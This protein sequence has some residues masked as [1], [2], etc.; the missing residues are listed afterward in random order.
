MSIK[1]VKKAASLKI[2]QQLPDLETKI[3]MMLMADRADENGVFHAFNDE[4]IAQLTEEMNAV[5]WRLRGDQFVRSNVDNG[6]VS[7]IVEALKDADV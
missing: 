4:L 3:L 2:P 1:H 6:R 7:R 5:I